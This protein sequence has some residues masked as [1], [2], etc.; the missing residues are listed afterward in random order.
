M[1]L[2][3]SR[4]LFSTRFFKSL[5]PKTT[6][7][8]TNKQTTKLAARV[9]RTARPPI[10]SL[11]KSRQ[12][13]FHTLTNN[14]S[15][16]TSRTFNLDHQNT[17]HAYNQFNDQIR[18]IK[19]QFSTIPA[20]SSRTVTVVGGGPAGLASALSLANQGFKVQVL[21]ARGDPDSAEGKAILEKGKMLLKEANNALADGDTD[22]SDMLFKEANQA[23]SSQWGQ[24][25]RNIVLDQY[26]L[27]FLTSLG[28]G[29]NC[30][31]N[32]INGKLIFSPDLPEISYTPFSRTNDSGNG[33]FDMPSMLLQR[34]PIALT[35]LHMIEQTLRKAID[36]NP[37]IDICFNAKADSVE[38]DANGVTINYGDKGKSSIKSDLLIVA[39]GGGKHSITSSLGI[40]QHTEPLEHLSW[41]VFDSDHPVNDTPSVDKGATGTGWMDISTGFWMLIG[42][43][44]QGTTTIGLKL[45]EDDPSDKAYQMAK[46]L[47]VKGT[48]REKTHFYS[49]IRKA[50]DFTSGKRVILAGN[51]AIALTPCMGVGAQAAFF[52]VQEVSRL[53]KKCSKDGLPKPDMKHYSKKMTAHAEQLHHLD[54][55]VEAMRKLST[56]PSSASL[57]KIEFKSIL[58]AIS[59][60]TFDL[61]QDSTT[62]QHLTFEM[63]VDAEKLAE[64]SELDGVRSLIS[65]MDNIHISGNV[66]LELLGDAIIIHIDDR[67]PIIFKN[68]H[69]TLSFGGNNA[70]I[71]LTY[72]DNNVFSNSESLK[73]VRQRQQSNNMSETTANVEAKLPKAFILSIL[74]YVLPKIGGIQESSFDNSNTP[75]KGSIQLKKGDIEI[76]PAKLQVQKGTKASIEIFPTATQGKQPEQLLVINLEGN[77]SITNLSSLIASPENEASS[78]SNWL[79]LF[80]GSILD[81]LAQFGSEKIDQI[82]IS[83]TGEV[84]LFSHVQDTS[85][86]L[87]S[88]PTQSPIL[89]HLHHLSDD[90][91]PIA[92]LSS[93]LSV[94]KEAHW[95]RDS[96]ET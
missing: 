89:D 17:S 47:G 87:I 71:Q 53:A 84:T 82:K 54:I 23:T 93:A 72:K 57:P 15:V 25:Y 83:S 7:A 10:H 94:T 46:E 18:L 8:Q 32:F 81:G 62:K 96:T 13:F 34:D 88:F 27:D 74:E 90:I 3:S 20:D 42:N 12:A 24:R 61:Y 16:S 50:S 37:A 64:Q 92:F 66:Q 77:I 35:T 6:T 40:G 67:H 68:A 5:L 28:V 70:S 52:E 58:P 31:S 69:E 80:H 78:N 79:N 33:T 43:D 14:Q 91:D 95:E 30:F 9:N 21:E 2:S 39:D 19:S 38:E 86:P 29:V 85:I 26:T 1:T 45:F 36:E 41:A 49:E 11:Q 4:P 48:L 44:G 56:E 55:S 59:S 65:T 22:K 75:I 76:G 73:I 51:A 60:L 63:S